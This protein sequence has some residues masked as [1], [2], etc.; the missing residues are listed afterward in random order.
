MYLDTPLFVKK[1]YYINAIGDYVIE[2]YIDPSVAEQMEQWYSSIS[3]VSEKDRQKLADIVRTKGENRF[4]ILRNKSKA[5]GLRRKL[6]R[7]FYVPK[8]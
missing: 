8:N 3:R 5:D 2:I 6:K 1:N 4:I 7:Y